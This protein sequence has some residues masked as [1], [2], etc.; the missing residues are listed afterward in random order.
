MY[1]HSKTSRKPLTS[2]KTPFATFTTTLPSDQQQEI[3]E[4]FDLFD[5]HAT[6]SITY[7]ELKVILR[8]LGFEVKKSEVVELARQYDV[9]ESGRVTFDDYVDI[10]RRKYAERDPIEEVL[11]AFRLFDEEGKG[12]ISL[13]DLK[14]V[15]RELG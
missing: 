8:A 6:Q 12:K 15:A 10:M 14:R 5:P 3:K 4:A 11:K 2:P 9:E 13:Y 7:H 1:T